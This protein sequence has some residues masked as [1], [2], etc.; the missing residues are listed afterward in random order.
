MHGQKSRLQRAALA[1]KVAAILENMPF[2]RALLHS[3][4]Q[5]EQFQFPVLAVKFFPEKRSQLPEQAAEML[6]KKSIV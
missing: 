4:E 2:D 6:H 3:W 1:L 5:S